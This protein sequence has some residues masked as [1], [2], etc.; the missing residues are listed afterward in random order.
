MNQKTILLRG[1]L[2]SVSGYGFHS[3]QIARWVFNKE[4]ELNLDIST[5]LFNWGHTGALV[6]P[7]AEN[8]LVGR[9]LQASDNRK[10]FYDVTIQVQLPSEWNPMLGRFNIG[11]TAG[12]ETD[13]CNPEWID[14][15]NQMNL[16]IVPS[17]FTKN[18]LMNSGKVLTEIKVIHES[19]IDE[20]KS[21]NPDTDHLTELDLPQDVNLLMFGQI[22]GNSPETDRKNLFYTIKW[23]SE[24]LADRPDVGIIIKTNM[25]RNSKVDEVGC[26]NILNQV[27]LNCK[28]GPGPNF[29]LLH[30]LLSNKEIAG[31]YRHPKITGFLTLGHGEGY[32]IPV[33]EAATSGLP[34]IAANWSGYLDFMNLGKFIKVPYKIAPVDSSKV[35]NKLFMQGS[36]WAYPDETEAKKQI[37][38]FVDNYKL[39]KE[40][41]KE[42]QAK[43]LDT[44]SF[45]AISKNYD[46]LLLPILT[47]GESR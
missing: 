37:S 3:R 36:Q 6:D 12:I 25:I 11:V 20:I 47:Q 22:T 8:G 35:D 10:P 34:V 14:A 1:P 5:E 45:D 19:F 7:G 4:E 29:Y 44:Y 9:I 39:P 41:A 2:N 40:W 30:G 46:Q 38:K 31:L 21:F 15:I 43:L 18:T 27:I 24:I 17:E 33:L 26:I 42:L 28:K 16:V 23:L 32:G 13:R